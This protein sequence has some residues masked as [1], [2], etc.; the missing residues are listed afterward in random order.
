SPRRRSTH[1]S[2]GLEPLEGR[3]LMTVTVKAANGDIFISGDSANNGVAVFQ[4]AIRRLFIYGDTATAIAGD[5][6]V[7]GAISDTNAGGGREFDPGAFDNIFINMGAGNDLVQVAG[8]QTTD[9][10]SL[11]IN[12][13]NATTGDVVS[14]GQSTFAGSPDIFFGFSAVTNSVSIMTGSGNDTVNIDALTTPS[15]SVNTGA[16]ADA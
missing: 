10:G 7:A 8:L 9:V 14:I 15:L 6:T 12:S 2:L 13:G 11:Q 4:D 3:R 1:R 16:G 5:G